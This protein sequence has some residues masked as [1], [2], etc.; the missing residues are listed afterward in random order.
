M[1]YKKFNDHINLV[2]VLYH[3]QFFTT[4]DLHKAR[5]RK[6]SELLKFFSMEPRRVKL[7][8]YNGR[9]EKISIIFRFL[10]KFQ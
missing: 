1:Y 9:S 6:H 7:L 8:N 3:Q 4:F 5:S 10:F 2:V